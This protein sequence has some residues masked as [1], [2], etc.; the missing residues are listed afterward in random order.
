MALG[1]L[2]P[3]KPF[4]GEVTPPVRIVWADFGEETRA[5]AGLPGADKKLCA[6]VSLNK[7]CASVS[8]NKPCRV[9]SEARNRR[10]GGGGEAGK[11]SF[12]FRFWVRLE[13]DPQVEVITILRAGVPPVPAASLGLGR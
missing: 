4:E 7:L 10:C 12:V 6:S 3:L 2:E 9:P 13:Q 5:C 1:S 8:L 11:D